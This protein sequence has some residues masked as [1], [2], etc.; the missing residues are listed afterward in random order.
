LIGGG[1]KIEVQDFLEDGDLVFDLVV[2]VVVSVFSILEILLGTIELSTEGILSSAAFSAVVFVLSNIVLESGNDIDL[3]G[4]LSEVDF[5][6]VFKLELE[7]SSGNTRSDF[8][9]L[10]SLDLS[11]DGIFEI[12][13]DVQKFSSNLFPTL[14]WAIFEFV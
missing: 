10:S 6:F 8:I 7:I 12:V 4:E 13:Q 9:V 2:L 14:S 3:L 11:G 5:D 1:R